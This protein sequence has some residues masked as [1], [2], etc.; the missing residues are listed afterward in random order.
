M[1]KFYIA[2]GS[3]LSV[4]QMKHRTP[5]ARI[6]GTAV[7]D[8]W[9]LTFKGCATIEP[10]ENHTT[11]VLVWEI[12]DRDEK[13]LDHYEGFP[14]FYYKKDLEVTVTPLDGGKPMELTAMVYIMDEKHFYRLPSLYY[15]DVLVKGYEAF[16]FDRK[17]LTA[18][19]A[20]SLGENYARAFEIEYRRAFLEEGMSHV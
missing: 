19:L 13:N 8:G 4:E 3:N 11:Q 18:S 17:K 6:V 10:K 2:Y 12:S 15:Y 1:S 16:G 20:E 5:D 9:G 7:L 14:T